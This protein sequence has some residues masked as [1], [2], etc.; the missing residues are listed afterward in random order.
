MTFDTTYTAFSNGFIRRM[1]DIDDAFKKGTIDAAERRRQRAAAEA[2]YYKAKA[3]WEQEQEARKNGYAWVRPVLREVQRFFPRQPRPSPDTDTAAW[4]WDP[5]DSFAF[6]TSNY[7]P[8]WL[9]KLALAQGQPAIVGGP[10]KSLKTSVLVDLAISLAS[11]TPFLGFFAVPQPR[12]VLVLSGESGHYTLQETAL[13]VAKARGI[14]FG[15]LRD[16]LIWQFNLPQLANATHMEALSEGLQ[17]HKI[18]ASLIDPTYLCLLGG[19]EPGAIKPE[20]IFSMGPLLLK[21]AACCLAAGTTPILAH[22]AGK[23]RGNDFEPIDLDD[24]SYAGFAEFARQWLLINRREAYEFDG[25]H[26][27]HLQVGGSMGHGGL[28]AL[29][30][31]E[32]LIDENFD[33]RVWQVRV[34][35]GVVARKDEKENKANQRSKEEE[36]QDMR[37]DADLL[38]ALDKLDSDRKGVSY[39]SVKVQ[40]KLSDNR[41][42]RAFE[43]L[44]A[45]RIVERLLPNK[46]KP[47]LGFRALGNNGAMRSC[48]G[49]RRLALG[50]PPPG[51]SAREGQGAGPLPPH[52]EKAVAWVIARFQEKRQ[53]LK[54]ELIE[55]GKQ[56]GFSRSDIYEA[57]KKLGIHKD[58]CFWELATCADG[59]TTF[60]W[61]VP[62]DWQPAPRNEATPAGAEEGGTCGS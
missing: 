38:A 14:Y 22:H 12:R 10:R 27:L 55:R 43:R 17:L 57:R 25:K 9:V 6:A 50:S 62:E 52:L 37:D 32:G 23:R 53:W 24:L 35:K 42:S 3:A 48:V 28:Y 26:Q 30:V 56:D 8:E 41:M 18:E 36:Q 44:I 4:A 46:D 21:I 61:M 49:L 31:E 47:E 11:G 59:K 40:S 58:S 54:E 45:E 33:G 29:D 60:L 51:S 39:N 15:D 34:K 19:S 13:R 2:E 5:I 16:Q 7:R 1:A 20:S